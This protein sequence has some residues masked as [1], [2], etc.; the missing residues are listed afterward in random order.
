MKRSSQWPCMCVEN[1]TCY[2]R[3]KDTRMSLKVVVIA[4]G[5]YVQ[6]KIKITKKYKIMNA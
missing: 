6:M 5:M 4:E 2:F 3:S 1:V